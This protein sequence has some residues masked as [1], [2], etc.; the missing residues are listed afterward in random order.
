MKRS[1]DIQG[2]EFHGDMLR[3]WSPL[4]ENWLLLIKHYCCIYTEYGDVPYFYNERANIGILSAAAWK[5]GWT[6]LKEFGS[7]KRGKKNG[8]TDL[9]IWDGN[10]NK[11]EYIEAKLGWK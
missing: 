10:R 11:G 6:A 8:R 2:F 3:Y 5:A 4:I 7:R 1:K 9:Y